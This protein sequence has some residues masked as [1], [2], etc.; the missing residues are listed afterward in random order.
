MPLIAPES[1]EAV[2]QAVDLVELVR[3]R[4]ELIRRGG[5]WTGRCPFHD[6]RSPSF[7]LI[8]PENR[9]YI[10]FGCGAKGD[11]VDWMKEKEGVGGF[12]EAIEA[13]A[14]RFGVPL[15]YES[16]S[17]QEEAE[18][19]SAAGRRELL[20]R[21]ADF[22]A[23]Y[24]W[25]AD[26]AAVARTYLTERG[27]SEELLRRF[28]VGYAPG[29]GD[30]LARRALK[31]GYARDQLESAGLGRAR[32]GGVQDFFNARITFPIADA[33]GRV[34]GFGARTLDPNQRAK[35]VNSP[36]GPN[37]QK[38]RLLFN[39][40]QARAQAARDG[41][42]VV[43]EGYT[44]VLAFAKAG[45]ENAVAC[46]GTSLTADQLRILA[47]VAPEVR[48]SFD[49]DRAG[50]DAAWRSVE[51]ARGVP[52]RLRAIIL[53]AG[54]DPGDLASSPEG[55]AELK[56]AVDDAQPLMLC[57]VRARIE[58]ADRGS[59]SERE[60]ALTDVIDLLRR[61]PDSLEKDEAVRLAS[62]LLGLS[63]GMTARLASD[64]RQQAA[65][66]RG[67]AAPARPA[68]VK[69]LSADEERERNLLSL[70][71]ALPEVAPTYLRDLPEEALGSEEHRKARDLLVEGV[72]PGTWPPEMASLGI[73]LQNRAA[74][75]AATEAELRE[76]VLRVE[77]P[78]LERRAALLREAGDEKELMN[79]LAL[80]HRLRTAT[81]G[82]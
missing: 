46:M 63:P 6:E 10:C 79:V 36:E 56:Q 21:A 67:A 82:G 24:L 1:V 30:V 5:R 44:D 76:A 42:M 8:P 28:K 34:L 77:L 39:L 12:Q 60:A 27:F 22:Y 73:D 29:A 35:Y 18:L 13:L 75:A 66:T 61:L 14:E 31:Q 72:R 59:V 23:E 7:S 16:T 25:R 20:E 11:A 50:Q 26:E 51:A 64:A 74:D 41:W 9:A 38:R 40:S 49:G 81:R 4:T 54:R 55:L 17:P 57:L 65:P 69:A 3:G 48:L 53:P 47:R 52:V 37:F 62:G 58:R 33:R 71:V 2:R 78:M 70:A 68:P 32:G 43:A 19:K 80:L 45:V 15:R